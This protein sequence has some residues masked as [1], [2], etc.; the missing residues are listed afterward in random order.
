MKNDIYIGI[1]EKNESVYTIIKRNKH[2]IAGTTCNCG[3]IPQYQL[4]IDDCFSL[5]EQLQ[6][7]YD[8]II[9]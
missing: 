2:L 9:F 4:L 6:E 5:D 7:L 1:V 3:I 8:L